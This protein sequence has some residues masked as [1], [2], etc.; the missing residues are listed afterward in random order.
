[1]SEN[2]KEKTSFTIIPDHLVR[3][4]GASSKKLILLCKLHSFH[5][6]GV[7]YNGGNKWLADYLGVG[8]RQVSKML[9]E[10]DDLGYISTTRKRGHRQTIKMTS[11]TI[12]AFSELKVSAGADSKV[13][14]HEKDKKRKYKGRYVPRDVKIDWL[15]DYI[16]GLENDDS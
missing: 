11:Q 4:F 15:D 14:Y 16:R 7:V 1:M 8:I 6:A 13:S 12:D 5:A 3:A 10:L 2:G 9:S